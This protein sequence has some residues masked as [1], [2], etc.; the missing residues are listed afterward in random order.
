M[1]QLDA[2]RAFAVASVVLCHYTYDLV[3]HF[4][5]DFGELGVKLFFT[6]SGFLITDILLRARRRSDERGLG[7]WFSL[8]RFYARRF[9]RIFPLYY[10]VLLACIALNIHPARELLGWLLTYTLNIQMS[11]TGVYPDSLSHL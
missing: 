4:V 3:G 10:C 9:L 11:I 1:P 2:L 8:R 6:L 5:D 7:K